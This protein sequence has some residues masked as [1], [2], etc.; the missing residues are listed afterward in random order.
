MVYNAYTPAETVNS[1]RAG[2][3]KV[4]VRLSGRDPQEHN[5]SLHLERHHS[6]ADRQCHRRSLVC[7][8]ILLVPVFP[9]SIHHIG[10]RDNLSSTEKWG[11]SR[12]RS[13]VEHRGDVDI[14]W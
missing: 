6:G 4:N 5:G 8:W 1:S 9:G 14:V 7:W 12:P 10:G 13:K 11:Q 2:V 3:A